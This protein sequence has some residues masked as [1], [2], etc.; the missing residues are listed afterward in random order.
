MASNMN[1]ESGG[2]GSA[3]HQGSSPGHSPK[4]SAH[5]ISSSGNNPFDGESEASAVPVPVP[6]YIPSPYSATDEAILEHARARALLEAF[7]DRS[8]TTGVA[9]IKK[10]ESQ[11]PA[12]EQLCEELMGI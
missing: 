10:V 12:F 3:A 4:S 7:K 9:E 8:V 6:P 11:V 1:E 2:V 5:Q